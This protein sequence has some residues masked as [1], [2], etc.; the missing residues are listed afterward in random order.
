M[1]CQFCGTEAT[2]ELNY[3]KR[4][5]GNLNPPTSLPVQDTRPPVSP[6]VAGAIGLTTFATAIGGLLIIFIAMA[7]LK[8]AGLPPGLLGWLAMFGAATIFGTITLFIWLWARVLGVGGVRAPRAPKDP[9]RLKKASF[10][11]E[12]SN[13]HLRSLPDPVPASVTEHTTRTFDAVYNEPRR[14]D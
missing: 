1:F 6:W 4:C 14:R 13:A 11:G 2:H 9:P 3:C 12:L 10:T 7:E 5:G 8:G